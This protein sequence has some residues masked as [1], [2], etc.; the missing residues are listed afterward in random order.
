MYINYYRPKCHATLQAC[1]HL[2]NGTNHA[3]YM[4]LLNTLQY[5]HV[6]VF[7]IFNG[8]NNS[9]NSTSHELEDE[10]GHGKIC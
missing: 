7:S 9:N 6:C 3:H 1:I 4:E 5:I 8:Y 2:N 10:R